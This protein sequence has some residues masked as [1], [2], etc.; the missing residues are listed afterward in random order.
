MFSQILATAA[1]AAQAA[2]AAGKPQG[3]PI[4]S[5]MPIIVIMV[6]FM[7]FMSRSQ[8]KQQ[9]KRQEMIDRTVKGTKVLLASGIR[10]VIDE[11]RENEFV[12]EIAPGVKITVVKHGVAEVETEEV[13]AEE[14]K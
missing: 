3:N 1:K 13:K 12:V 11:V 8:K 2:P 14:K 7:F 5:F 9:Q 6:V 10:G 4:M